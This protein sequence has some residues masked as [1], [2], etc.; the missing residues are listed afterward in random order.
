MYAVVVGMNVILVA[1]THDLIVCFLE[2]SLFVFGG[3]F[4]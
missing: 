4:L 2:D 3:G 1:H